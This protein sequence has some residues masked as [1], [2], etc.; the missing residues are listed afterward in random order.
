MGSECSTK[1]VNVNNYRY[2][3]TLAADIVIPDYPTIVA[4]MIMAMIVEAWLADYRE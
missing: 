4:L 2:I 1:P 3:G